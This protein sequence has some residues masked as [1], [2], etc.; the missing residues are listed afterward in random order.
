VRYFEFLFGISQACHIDTNRYFGNLFLLIC[1]TDHHNKDGEGHPAVSTQ[2][3]L[4]PQGG[5][6]DPRRRAWA[7]EVLANVRLGLARDE[8]GF[9]RPTV[10]P[11]P[12]SADQP[13]L[14]LFP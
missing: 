1:F 8:S 5:E 4:P 3:T 2:K 9:Y 13:Q 6:D 12:A 14:E 11:K 10:T 7:K